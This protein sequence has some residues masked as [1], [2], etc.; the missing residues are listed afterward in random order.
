MKTKLIKSIVKVEGSIETNKFG[1]VRIESGIPFKLRKTL[2]PSRVNGE[3]DKL[4]E[5]LK[6]GSSFKLRLPSAVAAQRAMSHASRRGRQFK[7]TFSSRTVD[8]KDSK[9]G[10]VSVRFWR[11]RYRAPKKRTRKA[12]SK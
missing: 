8:G 9:S 10:S 2:P 12:L 4:L 6:V 3:L 1:V 5:A 11:L 7:K